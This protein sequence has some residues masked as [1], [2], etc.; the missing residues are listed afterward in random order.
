MPV[1]ET[2]G[3]LLHADADAL[4][5]TVNCV[6][7]MGKG[8]ALQFKRQFPEMFKVYKRACDRGEV[9]IGKMLVWETG[10][11]EGPQ[12]IINF[13]TKQHWKGRSKLPWIRAGLEDL[14]RVVGELEIG[15][16][17]LPPL[18]AGNGG[19]DWT[20]VE[21]LIQDLLGDLHAEVTVFPPSREAHR[22]E[23]RQR[24]QM[25]RSRAL[26][27]ILMKHYGTKRELIEPWLDVFGVSHL[28][29]Q[30]LMYF[31]DVIDGTLRLD[32]APAQYGPYS[33]KV[34]L[35]L[36][37]MEG[38]YTEG[39][40]DGAGKVLSLDPIR[41]TDEGE[42]ELAR[43]LATAEGQGVRDLAQRV[44]VMTD[45]Y[46]DPYGVELLASTWCVA[47]AKQSQD[48]GV[49]AQGVRTWTKRKGQIFTD[50]QIAAALRH[51]ESVAIAV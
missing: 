17:A 28:E 6:G 26:A 25:S 5:N 30:K 41:V 38:R 9:Q 13:P 15:S 29:V 39:L 7:I 46:E 18:G 20:D 47:M 35:V 3:D 40:G 10:L 24:I 11:L 48:P 33:D 49:V 32:Y 1:V 34:R 4:V 36:Q 21:P 37:E 14:R 23:G 50:Q 44:L 16:V 42:R 51:L 43:Y 22:I 2:Q 8:I 27:L 31:A 12:Y 19:L 45:G